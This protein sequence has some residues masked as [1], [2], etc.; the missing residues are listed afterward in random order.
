MCEEKKYVYKV[1][2][3][4]IFYKQNSDLLFLIILY[5]FIII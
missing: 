5:F 3:H 1:N 4:H 2:K